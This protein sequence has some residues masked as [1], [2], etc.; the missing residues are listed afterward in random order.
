[1]DHKHDREITDNQESSTTS[2]GHR[3]AQNTVFLYLMTF[4]T[5]ALNLLTIP[6][7]TRVLGPTVY[8]NIGLAVGYMLYIQIIL[9][10]GFILSATQLISENRDDNH[11][12]SMIIT[13]VTLIKTMLCCAG[14]LVCSVQDGLF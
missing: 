14:S 1:M 13:S 2:K 7:L 6:Y 8:G 11:F 10:F 12:A 3:L 9:D 4:S 5:Y